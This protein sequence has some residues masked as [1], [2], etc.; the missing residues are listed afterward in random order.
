MTFQPIEKFDC[1]LLDA[2]CSSLGTFRRNPDVSF[3]IKEMALRDKQILQLKMLE[4]ASSLV[5]ENGIIIYMVCSFHSIETIEVID[6]F[7]KK[8]IDFNTINLK[9]DK[10]LK[11]N[12]G[13]FINPLSFKDFG[14]SDSF[15]ISVLQKN[16]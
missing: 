3:K 6:K 1:I 16:V 10:L 5:S 13:Y 12:D 4:K 15:F 14:G 2:P 7:L 8:N 9:S 11:K